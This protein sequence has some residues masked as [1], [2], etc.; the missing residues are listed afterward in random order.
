MSSL[1]GYPVVVTDG[2]WRKSLSA[3]RSLGKAGAEVHVL[4]DSLFTTGYWSAFT[5]R[6]VRVPDAARDEDAFHEGMVAHLESLARPPVVLPMEEA[7]IRWLA[8]RS[9]E[10]EGRARFLIPE[11]SSLEVALDKGKTSE[12]AA[13]GGLPVPR[14][15]SPASAEELHGVVTE[16]EPGSFVVKPVEGS[17]STG[18]VY[19]EHRDPE[20]WD[21][22]WSELGPMIVQERI[23]AAGRAVGVACLFDSEGELKASFTHERLRQYPVTGGPSTDRVSIHHAE[24]ERMSVTLLQGL[25]WRGIGMAEWKEDPATGDFKLL[26]INPRFWGSLELAVRAGVD[27]PALYARA[28]LGEGLPSP[29]GYADGVRCRWMIP[30]EVLR[31]L[32]GPRGERESPRAFL[33]GLPRVAEEWDA[34]DKRGAL[35]TVICTGA[36]ALN[37]RYWRYVRR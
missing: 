4:G 35:A 5:A 34:R 23:P 14:T 16:L 30:G 20:A 11:R 17:G 19:G 6:R 8:R 2:L 37:P 29:P 33:R 28:A 3:I 26:E 21:T 22:A 31:Y 18:V 7:T 24:L 1:A 36:L 15:W 32:S 10:I 27:F 9:A 12:V 25:R 13:Q